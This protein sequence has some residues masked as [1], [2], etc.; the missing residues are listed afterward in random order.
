MNDISIE[1]WVGFVVGFV[2][3]IHVWWQIAVTEGLKDRIK[4]LEY[5]VHNEEKVRQEIDNTLENTLEDNISNIVKAVDKD[6]DRIA[7]NM[8][9]LLQRINAL[10][11]RVGMLEKREDVTDASIALRSEDV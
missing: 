11:V 4:A 5:T 6:T 3:I 7:A 2:L 8:Q 1:M 10:D 9:T